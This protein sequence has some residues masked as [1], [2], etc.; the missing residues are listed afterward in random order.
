MV[1]LVADHDIV[2]AAHALDVEFCPVHQQ[3]NVAGPRREIG[4]SYAGR[5]RYA[6]G[7]SSMSPG[8]TL[9]RGHLCGAALKDRPTMIHSGTS[10]AY[11]P[12]NERHHGKAS[13]KSQGEDACRWLQVASP[14]V[15][16]PS[17]A[18]GS[19]QA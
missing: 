14:Y 17:D 1:I 6:A 10:G 13:P 2:E 4:T 5:S 9:R 8:T 7:I 11:F 12:N 16:N 3:I 19:A 15:A 18:P